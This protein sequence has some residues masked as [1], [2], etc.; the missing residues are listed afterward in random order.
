VSNKRVK[1]VSFNIKNPKEKVFLDMLESESCE[2][3]RYVKELIFTDIER[4]N[5]ALRIVK[6]SEN[7]GIKIEVGK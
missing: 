2:F 6:R 1:S 3:S 7:G 5:R 4:R